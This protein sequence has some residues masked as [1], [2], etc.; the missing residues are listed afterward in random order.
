MIELVFIAC[1]SAG[2]S[3]CGERQIL[4]L[5]DIG[6]MGCMTTAQAHL[7]HWTEQHPGYRIA[8]WSCGWAN[9]DER[10]A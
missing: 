9:P 7:A 2:G 4:Q 6:L 10:E 8:R 1:L 5:P 3:S